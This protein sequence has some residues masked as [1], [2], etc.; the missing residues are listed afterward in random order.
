VN[1]KTTGFRFPEPTK[2]GTNQAGSIC[3]SSQEAYDA[4]KRVKAKGGKSG[5]D[6]Q[7]KHSQD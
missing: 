4:S 7:K 3:I 6:G 2:I 1:E 5:V